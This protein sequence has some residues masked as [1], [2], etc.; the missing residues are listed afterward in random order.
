M[1]SRQIHAGGSVVAFDLHG[2]LG[3][4]LVSRIRPEHRDRVVAIDAHG[5]VDS[6]VGLPI[7]GQAPPE[8]RERESALLVAA[9]RRLSSDGSELY[10][11]FRLERIFD[12]F[13]RL[14]QEEG[15]TLHDLHEL[16]TDA[17]RRSA[18]RLA[19]RSVPVARFL[20]ELAPLLARNPEFLWPA[21]ARVAKVALIPAVS[22]LLSPNGP[23]LPV[24]DLLSKG[25]SIVWRLPFG[26]LGPETSAFVASLLAGRVYLDRLSEGV[27][28]TSRPTILFLLDEAQAFAPMLLTEILSEG[29]KFGVQALIATQYPERL[30]SGLRAAA[31]G[32]VGTHLCFRIPAAG[33][34]SAG[35]WFGLSRSEAERVL[36]QLPVGTALKAGGERLTL[37][38]VPAHTEDSGSA[39][40]QAVSHA[41]N[42]FRSDRS[43]IRSGEDLDPATE[44]I[45][46]GIFALAEQGRPTTEDAVLRA[47]ESDVVS[48]VD[49]EGVLGLLP[50][51][52]RRGWLD[53]NHDA[54]FLTP[55][56]LARLGYT[57]NTG[58]TKET[59]AHRALI[60]DAFRI[61]ARRGY[62]LEIL[63]QGRFDYRVPDARF[64]QVPDRIR[65]QPPDRLAAALE[66]VRTGW[67]WKFFHGKD[68]HVEAEV[69]GATRAER[70]H[71]G[72]TK[73]REA[74]AFALFV[75]G[76]AHRAHTVRR[77]LR[78][79]GKSI[80]EAQVWT[81]CQS[82]SSHE[83]ESAL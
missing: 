70:I 56:G 5:S 31:Q 2:D 73:A 76:D 79:E 50:T 53:R 36:P 42:A 12:T 61:F 6:L 57:A 72:L 64:R 19:T 38:R 47:V 18:A 39:W 60:L 28:T 17:R 4:R 74:H 20:D 11:G 54:W 1:G 58:A 14:V 67:A 65:F 9:L 81:L 23:G 37:E 55:A 10:W 25:R 71:H 78:T 66:R 59:V 27:P 8:H 69:S 40:A 75:V 34:A 68:V 16:L 48:S 35:A 30:P 15:G 32:A 44:S 41:G 45:L 24:R 51:L 21:A 80:G 26:V 22:A 29:R 52:A 33:A 49:L 3:P 63:R 13:V 46:L 62:R 82:R 43:W 7:L 77:I 83:P